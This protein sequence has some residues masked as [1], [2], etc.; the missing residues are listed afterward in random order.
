LPDNTKTFDEFTDSRADQ[1]EA[2]PAQSNAPS[3]I[4]DVEAQMRQALNRLGPG[5]IL[6]PRQD[7]DRGDGSGGG[8]NTMRLQDRF[9]STH[10]RRFVQDGDVPV[11][12]VQR[13]APRDTAAAAP[14]AAPSALAIRLQRAEAD[15]AAQSAARQQAERA[16][17]E[18]QAALRDLR[19]KLGHVELARNEAVEALR[20]DREQQ[21][22]RRS[23]ESELSARQQEFEEQ[24]RVLQRNLSAA[25][26]E[27]HEERAQRKALEKEL[28]SAHD[29]RET[30]ERLVRVLS[31]EDK[32]DAT[33][34]SLASRRG[35]KPAEEPAATTDEPEPVKWWLNNSL[36]RRR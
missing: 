1:A 2:G 15:L 34:T 21:A 20:R 18:A 12:Y 4:D 26:S 11:A 29:A 9:G 22:L 24:L 27:L 35:R 23:A 13:N 3:P 16:M 36:A 32:D 5:G 6:R 28:R 14:Q 31:E 10:R 7:H 8:G 25:Q 33:V 30:A 19:T 17:Q